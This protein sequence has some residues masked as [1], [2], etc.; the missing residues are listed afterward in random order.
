MISVYFIGAGPGDPDLITVKG[1]NILEKADMIIYAGSLVPEAVISCRKRDCIVYNSAGM[2]LDE[3]IAAIRDGVSRGMTVA[4]VH[5]GDPSIY[6]AVREQA[7]ALDTLSI[8]YEIVPGVSSFTAAAAALKKEFTVP[9]VSQTVIC[10]RIEGRTP[11]PEKESLDSLAA[12]RASMSIFLSAHLV[13]T[14]V[15]KLRFHYPAHTPAAVVQKVSREDQ[16]IVIGTLADIAMKMKEEKIES[17]AL[18]L[19]GDF[20]GSAPERSKLYDK[21]FSHGFRRRRCNGE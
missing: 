16:K 15:E 1:R 5:T 12:H 2:D 9:G 14:V 21:D 17:T 8:S 7:D 18:I 11:V 10:T 6:G 13:E 20:L 4:R 3:I 19:V